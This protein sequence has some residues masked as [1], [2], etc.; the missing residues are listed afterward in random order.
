MTEP[1]TPL[2]SQLGGYDILSE[3]GRGGMGSVYL[4]RRSG[5]GG[6]NKFVAIKRVHPHLLQEKDFAAMFLDEA[7][8][9]ATVEHPNVA[10]VFELAQE[11]DEHLL[12]MEYLHGASLDELSGGSPGKPFPLSI[13]LRIAAWAAEGL[14]AA[15]EAKDPAGKRLGLVHRD[16]TP[17]NIFVT[18]DGRVKLTDFGVS[19]AEG[20]LVQTQSGWL[21]GKAAYL[22][23]EQLQGDPIDRRLDVFSLGIVVWEMLTARRLFQGESQAESMMAIV[24]GQAKVP[25]TYNDAIDEA[26]DA[27]V[28]KALATSPDDRFQTAQEFKRALETQLMKLDSKT[29]QMTGSGE[30]SAFVAS[31][32]PNLR[33]R[34][35]ALLHTPV[36]QEANSGVKLRQATPP[37]ETPKS[38]ETS[39]KPSRIGVVAFL[40]LSVVAVLF[41]VIMTRDDPDNPVEAMPETTSD[42]PDEAES[43]S[44]TLRI[45]SNP[46]GAAIRLD[47]QEL[48]ERTPALLEGIPRGAHELVLVLDGYRAETWSLDLGEAREDITV[49]LR[50]NAPPEVDDVPAVESGPDEAPNMRRP[51]K[52]Q[53]RM[54]QAMEPA[55]ERG[56]AFLNLITVPSVTVFINGR[57]YG[58][59]P[60]RRRE[61]PSGRV[62]LELRPDDGD[63]RRIPIDAE[64]GQTIAV[65]RVVL[66]R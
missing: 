12:V 64:P 44:T 16:V 42:V 41:A 62:T 15:H 54:E 63:P 49:A 19:K 48:Q 61:I 66:N 6:F 27:L 4:G 7:R 23:P 10:Q 25:S 37:A 34:R 45:E 32:L 30:V 39:A 21:K 26:L 17:Q 57:S 1:A 11:G 36:D 14:H 28:M 20:R 58:R 22:G 52:M 53:A 46:S 43:N 13:S 38:A 60:M 56:P 50:P 35:D 47:G 3:L 9:A 33:S 40:T 55:A 18:F 29:E 5:A 31:L 2:P 24:S 8:I 65:P 59:T 51:T